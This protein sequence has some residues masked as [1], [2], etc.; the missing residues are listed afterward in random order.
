MKAITTILM[1]TSLL[2]LGS[3]SSLKADHSCCTKSKECREGSCKL[4]KSCC[5]DKCNKC[6]GEK[7]GCGESCD[8]KK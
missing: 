2:I 7:D 5:D 6:S 1:T 3:C 8:L 4:D